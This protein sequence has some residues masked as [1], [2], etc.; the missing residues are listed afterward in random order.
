MRVTVAKEAGFCFGVKRATDFVEKELGGKYDI[1]ILGHLIHNRIYNEHLAARGAKI[2][3][4]EE[5]E[6]IAKNGRE[7]R[8]IIRTHGIPKHE[9]EFLRSIEKKYPNIHI[10]DM[11]CPFVKKIHKI[12]DENTSADTTLAV[13]GDPK[14]PEVLSILSYAKGESV[15]FD[16]EESL[17]NY[18][19]EEKNPEKGIILVAQTTQNTNLW[20]KCEKKFKKVYTNAIIFDTICSVTEK[21]Q[22]ETKDLALHSD[23]MI[24][25][26]GKQSSNSHKLFEIASS[27]CQKC[28]FVEKADELD[29]SF[30]DGCITI[31]ITAG[32]STPSGIIEEVYKTMAELENFEELLEAS[33]KTLNTGDTVVGTVMSV[34]NNEIRLDL[35]AKATGVIT[36]DQITDEPGVDLNTMFKVGD[37]VEGFVI[38]VSDIDGIAVLSKKRVDSD[39]NWKYIVE[40]KENDAVLEGKIV[41]AVKGGVLINLNGVR[42]FIPASL[43]G[44]P[45]GGDLTTL[46]GTTQRVKIVDINE[47]RHKAYASI[48][49]VLNEERKAR[50]EAFW[51][52]VEEGKHYQG[53]VKNLATYGAFVDLGGVDGMVHNSE[54]S[55]KHIKHPSQ[56]VK[57][58]DV[59]DVWVKSFDKETGKISLGYKTDDMNSWF[60]FKNKYAVGDVATVKIVSFTPF[61]AFAEIVP[62]TDGLIHISQISKTKIAQ[63]SD[64]LEIGQEVEVKII[65]INEEKEKVSLSIR[66]LIEEAEAPVV[67]EA[68]AEEAAAEEATAEE[69]ATDAE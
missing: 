49:A 3:T 39:K 9:E 60:V 12:A 66:A 64:V 50:E 27:A 65:D 13:I 43:T 15:V 61:G 35:G 28:A 51:A 16:S 26:G 56:V 42:V 36:Y 24:V 5:V 55:W 41:E 7:A 4:V 58:G 33:L 63:P 59:I 11:T 25:I 47:Q 62:G 53:T 40:A 57:V 18:V 29:K 19:K 32:A 44:V 17:E 54:L 6:D 21:R 69:A 20:K 8:V 38:K 2:T 10:E 37:Q 34:S 48:R 68:S 67:E 52:A 30:F 46:V 31:G 23:G 22:S 1:Y 14:H 45:K